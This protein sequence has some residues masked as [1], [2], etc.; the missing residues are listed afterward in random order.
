M[1]IIRSNFD[2]MDKRRNIQS[3][4]QQSNKIEERNKILTT[5][6][7]KKVFFET[8]LNSPKP[9]P[10]L[11]KALKRYNEALNSKFDI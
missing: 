11:K 2:C 10:S 4:H 7:D 3:A 6:K 1:Q 9:K 5:E 8:L